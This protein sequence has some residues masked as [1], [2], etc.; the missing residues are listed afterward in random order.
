[1]SGTATE[2]ELYLAKAELINAINF[3]EEPGSSG[4]VAPSLSKQLQPYA[5]KCLW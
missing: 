2:P 4:K 3:S 5:V 1:M